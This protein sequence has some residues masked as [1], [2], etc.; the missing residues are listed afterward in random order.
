MPP[1]SAPRAPREG[2]RGDIH[3]LRGLAIGLVVAYHLWT[4]GR[5]S[6]GVDVFLFISAFLMTASF[7]RKGTSFTLIDFLVQRFR[8]LV[9]LAAL[10]LATTLA[11]GWWVL[12]PTRYE[13]LFTHAWASLLYRENWQLIDD[14][15]NYMVPDPQHLNPFQHFW[16]LSLQGQFFVLL[17]VLFVAAAMIERR[18]SIPLRRTLAVTLGLASVVSFAWATHLVQ[19]SPTA[20]YFDTR[21]R[22]WEFTAAALVALLPAFTLSRRMSRVM[23]WAGLFLLLA[24]GL[25]WGRGSFPSFAAVPPLLAA[26]LVIL[27]GNHPD[28]R[29]HASAWLARRPLTFVANRAYAL[30]LWHWPVYVFALV[31]TSNSDPHTGWATSAVVLAISLLLADASTRLVERRF[32]Q[33]PKLTSLPYAAAAIGVSALIAA[34]TVAGVS[35]LVEREDRAIA[36]LPPEQRPGARILATGDAPTPGAASPTPVRGIAP[37]DIG[38]TR[39]WPVQYEPCDPARPEQPPK[40]ELGWCVVYEEEVDVPVG[41]VAIVGDSHAY[42]WLTAIIPL[43]QERDWRVIAYVRP[44]CRVGSPSEAEGCPEYTREAIDWLLRIRPDFVVSTGSSTRADAPEH[45]DWGWAEAIA[46]LAEAGLEIVNIR[47]NPRWPR[48][49]PECAQRYGTDDPRC[50][51]LRSDKLAESWP[52]GALADLPHQHYL[53]FSDWFCPPGEVSVCPAVIGNTYVYMD[54]NHLSRAYVETLAEVFTDAWDREVGS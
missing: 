23:S 7:V 8:R 13:N 44:A 15:A 32:H 39:D 38:V 52:R 28:D 40:P 12:P 41:T 6:G 21:A 25:V 26:A 29:G 11:V 4:A 27:A 1:E 35:S 31:I 54:T 45:D 19:V 3:G 47:D 24:S 36:D 18:F 50:F 48:D 42:Q 20:A 30:Y 22:T 9:P 49:M 17:P 53:D 51:A 33:I 34:S 37:G 14:S 2:F 43:A 16:S 46:P 10:V 5:V